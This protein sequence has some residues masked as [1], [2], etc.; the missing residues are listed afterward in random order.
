MRWPDAGK[1]RSISSPRWSAR[2]IAKFSLF[3]FEI[4]RTLENKEETFRALDAAFEYHHIFLPWEMSDETFPWRSDP[5]W[6]EIRAPAELP[7]GLTG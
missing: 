6:Q 7:E 5:R 4:Q 1:R 3:L 2:T